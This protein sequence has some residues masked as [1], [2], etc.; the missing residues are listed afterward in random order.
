M[1]LLRGSQSRLSAGQETTLQATGLT[2]NTVRQHGGRKVFEIPLPD[3]WQLIHKGK[4]HFV[5]DELRRPRVCF[6]RSTQS[7]NDGVEV[8]CIKRLT[9]VLVGADK[10]VVHGSES[11]NSWS[12][13][14]TLRLR[15]WREGGG[16]I[17]RGTSCTFERSA[18]RQQEHLNRMAAEATC[19]LE[20]WPWL[21]EQDPL[22][23]NA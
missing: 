8:H 7:A 20:L 11:S 2:I 12:S 15:A 1:I 10:F 6:E 22:T 17:F 13:T 3:G 5:L 14:T 18:D 16:P 21:L 23:L 9:D 4:T 19:L